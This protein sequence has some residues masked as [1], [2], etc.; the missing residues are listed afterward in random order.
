MINTRFPV[1]NPIGL[2]E[3]SCDRLLDGDIF[4]PLDFSFNPVEIHSPFAKKSSGSSVFWSANGGRA[5]S[6]HTSNDCG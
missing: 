1:H 4:A 5:E 6:D 2:T 3:N